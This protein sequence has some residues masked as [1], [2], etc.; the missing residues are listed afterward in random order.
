MTDQDFLLATI[1]QSKKTVLCVE[2]LTNIK[3]GKHLLVGI[4]FLPNKTARETAAPSWRKKFQENIFGE[5]VV[6]DD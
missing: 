5:K 6:G 4:K 2:T 3:R 1:N